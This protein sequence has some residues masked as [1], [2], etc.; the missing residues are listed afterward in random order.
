MEKNMDKNLKL[1]YILLFVFSMIVVAFKTL[2]NFFG[3]VG[4]NCVALLVLAFIL[5]ITMLKDKS[6]AKRIWDMF[7]ISCAILLLEL[8]MYF[9]CE[10]GYGLEIEA[11]EI[12]QNIISFFGI[13][14][15]SYV[16]L[17]FTFDFQNKKLKFIEILL[18]NEKRTPKERKP[19]KSKEITNGSLCD[20]PNTKQEDINISSETAETPTTEE[21][22]P[23]PQ[24][25]EDTTIIIETEE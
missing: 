19:K 14:L 18:G 16:G 15:L 24:T 6:V 20:K 23:E 4:I 8:V 12:L 11:F 10:F 25:Q 1:S 7:T 5:M 17:R 13:L 9:A 22:N 3:G 21:T 2:T